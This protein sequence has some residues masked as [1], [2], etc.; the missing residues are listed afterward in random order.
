M[1]KNS[2]YFTLD[3]LAR[4]DHKIKKLLVNHG[5]L[6]YGVYWSI[7]EDLYNNANA[8]PMD[9]DVI[10]FDLRCNADI[11]KSIINDYDLFTIDGEYFSSKSVGRRLAEREEKSLIARNSANKRWSQKSITNKEDA[12]ALHLQCDRNA[13]KEKKGKEK[14]ENIFIKP[15]NDEVTLYCQERNNNVNPEYFF[16]YYEM[17][18]WTVGKN[19]TPMK[20]WKAA[21]RTWEK[22]PVA[23]NNN[24]GVGES[25]N[26]QGERTYGRG[27]IVPIEAPPRPS[28]NHF[29]H[30][31]EK[32][33]RIS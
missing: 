32:E 20:D 6:G 11:V 8:L 30:K 17:R 7:I 4:S 24:L 3:Y 13:I 33:W 25:I 23:T 31:A 10:A 22:N 18:G 2:F 19:N 27:V 29:W 1:K 28:S 26:E 12:I 16:N 9:C 5:M 15:T 14:K 21:V